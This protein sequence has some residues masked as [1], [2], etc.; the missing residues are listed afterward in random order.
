MDALEH[1]QNVVMPNRNDFVERPTEYR[2]LDNFLCSM[3]TVA[4]RLGLD[5]LEYAK[6]GRGQ[7]T[8]EAQKIRGQSSSLEHLKFCVDTLK[9]GRKIM[10]HGGGKFTTVATSTGIDPNNPTT[11]KIG[12]HDL[13]E[14]AHHAFATLQNEFQKVS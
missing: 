4:E 5:E 2:C 13:V 3:N 9:H 10:D 12:E 8:Q 11:W 14:V 6:V 7:L 1:F